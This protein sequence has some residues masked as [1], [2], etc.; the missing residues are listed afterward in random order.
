MLK[1][2]AMYYVYMLRC[3]DNTLYTGVTTQLNRRVAEHNAG[4][5]KGAKYT[6][7]RLPVCLVYAKKHPDRSAAQKEEARI[8][9]LSRQ[10]KEM[11]IP[12]TDLLG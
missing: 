7:A 11:L 12:T 3:S 1:Q 2:Y 10:Q 6:R 5:T 4:S 8:K 9:K